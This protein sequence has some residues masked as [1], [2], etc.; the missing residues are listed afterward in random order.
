MKQTFLPWIE[1]CKNELDW[2]TI[3]STTNMN[4]VEKNP[5]KIVW[6][7][8]SQNENAISFLEKNPTKICW[9]IFWK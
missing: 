8:L 5:D 2:G 3:S 9:H 6:A 7:R 1:L 4:I